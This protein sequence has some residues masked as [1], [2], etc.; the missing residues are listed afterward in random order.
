MT[1]LDFLKAFRRNPN[2]SWTPT[3]TVT[4]GSVT[5]GPGVAFS[6]GVAFGGVD[7]AA[8]LNRLAAKYPLLVRT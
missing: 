5:M 1:E 8:E 7:V 3:T 2:G 4:I 6:V